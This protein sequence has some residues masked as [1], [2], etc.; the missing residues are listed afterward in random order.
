[1]TRINRLHDEMKNLLPDYLHEDGAD[2]LTGGRAAEVREHLSRCPECSGELSLLKELS[3]MDALSGEDPGDTFWRSLGSEAVSAFKASGPP[4][5]LLGRGK[6]NGR[7]LPGLRGFSRTLPAAGRAAAA[8]AVAVLALFI[9][10]PWGGK[11]KP[12]GMIKI[13]VPASVLSKQVSPPPFQGGTLSFTGPQGDESS[14]LALLDN[15]GL[16]R[17]QNGL[18]QEMAKELSPDGRSYGDGGP[19]YDPYGPGAGYIEDLASLSGKDMENL[20]NSLNQYEK[21]RT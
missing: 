12:G 5:A 6:Q 2:A 7:F 14:A 9:Y 3:G 4:P 1:M 19:S 10:H 21:E 16:A 8:A 20:K 13:P 17:L 11:E 15:K 18:A